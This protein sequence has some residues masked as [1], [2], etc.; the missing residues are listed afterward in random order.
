MNK[1]SIFERVKEEIITNKKKREAGEDL[2]IPWKNF[3]KLSTAIPGVQRGRYVIIT[4]ASKSGKSQTCDALYVM[5]P[6]EYIRN[7]PTNIKPK[8]Y[9]FS[10][11][12]SK[13]DKITQ[14]LSNKIYK[15]T[16]FII[17]P[18]DLKSYFTNYIAEDWIIELIESNSYTEYFKFLEENIEYI[19]WIKHATGIYSHM[20]NIAKQNGK[21]YFKGKEVVIPDGADWTK[22]PYDYYEPNN[23]D[24]FIIVIIDHVSLLQ[25]EGNKT[26]R[27]AMTLFSS[28]YCLRMRDNFK[29]CVVVIQQQ[30]MDSDKPEYNHKGE[31]ILSKIR[32]STDGF[33]DSKLSVRDADLVIGVFNPSKYGGVTLYPDKKNGYD[34]ENKWG[35]NYREWS[36]I[37]NRRGE[38]NLNVHTYFNGAINYF[39]EIPEPEKFIRNPELYKKY[40]IK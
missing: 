39:E 2:V 34:I 16:G 1:E 7:H 36:I 11:E 32:P 25:A 28:V 26:Q 12:M 21:F 38:G 4:G 30:S 8:I 17:R 33:G 24:E 22:Y 29:F 15:D 6:L 13:E 3:P 19:D 9:Y 37:V 14:L 23:S 40:G 10:L 35:N 18:D 20:R 5:E 31:L 27:D